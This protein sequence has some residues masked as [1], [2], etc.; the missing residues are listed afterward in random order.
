MN[1]AAIMV[2]DVSAAYGAKKALDA[3]SLCVPRG[4]HFALLGPNGAGK[5]TLIN[6]LCTLR[7]ADAGSASV[8]GVDVAKRPTEARRSIGVVF[9]DSSL[10]D[11]LSAWENLEFHGLVY[12][13]AKKSRRQ[14]IETVL[15]L[16]EL[17]N[18]THEIV[19]SFSGGMRRRLEIARALLHEPKILFLDEPTVGL[20]AQTRQRIWHYLDRLRRERDL[21][22]LTTTHYIEEVEGADA[23]CIIDGGKIIAE[24]TP[25]ALKKQY[26]QRW[27]HVVPQN[28]EALA[29]IR[30]RFPQAQLIGTNTL[31]F[32]ENG[33][34]K[35]D[36]IIDQFR[37]RLAEVRFLPPTLESVFL[38]LT[39]RELRDRADGQRDADR[40]AGRRGGRR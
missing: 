12:G 16:V 31:A 1:D 17:E 19:R 39:G 38:S 13:M 7:K 37:D 11:R 40:A 22:V 35:T 26:G 28:G 3:V 2:S 23:V 20:D 14:M 9:Q 34:V 21:T 6:I 25:E 33:E 32:P 29:A 36:V 10:D 5:T 4:S 24:G 18:W 30:D 15:N 8:A 27:L